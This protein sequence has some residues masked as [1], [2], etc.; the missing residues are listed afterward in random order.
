M[1]G[2]NLIF[3]GH[4]LKTF[5]SGKLSLM[6][7]TADGGPEGDLSFREFMDRYGAPGKS[8]DGSIRFTGVARVSKP[9]ASTGRQLRVTGYDHAT[10]RF[11]PDPAAVRIE[12]F[13]ARHWRKPVS[14]VARARGRWLEPEACSGSLC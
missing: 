11:S 4:E 5:R 14:L 2:R 1:P 8:G 10:G 13:D 3:F 9:N 12:Q 6:T 7:P